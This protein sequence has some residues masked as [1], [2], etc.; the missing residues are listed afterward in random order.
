MALLFFGAWRELKLLLLSDHGGL[1]LAGFGISQLF[2]RIALIDFVDLETL[3]C[4]ETFEVRWILVF[5]TRHLDVCYISG[6]AI[7]QVLA[8][9]VRNMPAMATAGAGLARYVVVRSV[10]RG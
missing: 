2:V 9:F 4:D 10:E 8:A 1:L 6:A 7:A 5:E 3:F